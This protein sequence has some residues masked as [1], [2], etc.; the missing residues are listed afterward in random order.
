M[1][2]IFQIILKSLAFIHWNLYLL[3]KVLCFILVLNRS[4]GKQPRLLEA[5]R[6]ITFLKARWSRLYLRIMLPLISVITVSH[7]ILLIPIVSLSVV[8]KLQQEFL[9]SWK[10]RSWIQSMTMLGTYNIILS[11]GI[12]YELWDSWKIWLKLRRIQ[13]WNW[14]QLCIKLYKKLKLNYQTS[15]ILFKRLWS[16]SIHGLMPNRKI[17]ISKTLFIILILITQCPCIINQQ[18]FQI[19]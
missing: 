15:G 9:L 2:E 1:E 16:N 6:R 18:A 8:I 12:I 11:I 13:L 5:R 4:M 17:L 3:I 10:N 19:L 14:I 7:K